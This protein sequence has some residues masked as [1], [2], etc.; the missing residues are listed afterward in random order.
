[1]GKFKTVI[2]DFDGT[3]ADTKKGIAETV[4]KVLAE[5][6]IPA[7]PEGDVYGFIG[8]G[9]EK[10]FAGLAKGA[11]ERTIAGMSKRYVE[12]YNADAR[13][14]GELFPHVKETL[15]ALKRAGLTLAVGTSKRHKSTELMLERLGIR[16]LFSAVVAVDDV[17]NGKPAPDIAER[18]LELT[19]TRNEDALLVGDTTYDIEMGRNAGIKTCA[20]TY[21]VHPRKLL[22]KAEPDFILGDIRGILGIL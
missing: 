10:L 3:L 19:G 11:D 4:N 13:G 21:G 22:E 14:M 1:M 7:V 2:F 12:L 6:G 5:R 17:K 20:V 18:A 8:V 15:L 16:G 9:V